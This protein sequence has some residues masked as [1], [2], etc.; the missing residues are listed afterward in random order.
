MK[1]WRVCRRC[2]KDVA[3]SGRWIG[4][5]RDLEVLVKLEGNSRLEIG[6]RDGGAARWKDSVKEMEIDRRDRRLGRK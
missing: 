4:S 2:G 6:R 3:M 5:L 1:N